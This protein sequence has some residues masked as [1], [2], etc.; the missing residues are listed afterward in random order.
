LKANSKKDFS[1][2][3]QS[4]NGSFIKNLPPSVDWRQQGFVNPIKN[5]GKFYGS[6]VYYSIY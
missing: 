2:K 3:Y 1:V 4:N 5:Q 6:F